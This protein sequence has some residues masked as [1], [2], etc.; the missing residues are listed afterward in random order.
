MY[1]PRY[2]RK[3]EASASKNNLIEITLKDA[4]SVPTVIFKGEEITA[5]RSIKFNW[6]TRGEATR[7]GDQLNIDIEHL[8]RQG[9]GMAIERKGVAL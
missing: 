8:T 6:L 3:K 7:I 2:L 4:G 5:K 9:D 1:K